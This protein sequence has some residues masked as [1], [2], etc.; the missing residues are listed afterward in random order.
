MEE[1]KNKREFLKRLY[2]LREEA[3]DNGW[4]EVSNLIATVGFK[5]NNEFLKENK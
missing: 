2:M 1:L 3:N 5:I 4:E